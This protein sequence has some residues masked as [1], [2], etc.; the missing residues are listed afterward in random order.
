LVID[1]KLGQ[2]ELTWSSLGLRHA[3]NERG[4]AVLNAGS[5]TRGDPDAMAIDLETV[6]L[7]GRKALGAFPKL[8]VEMAGRGCFRRRPE[9][10]SSCSQ[11]RR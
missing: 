2:H 4:K 8:Q 9:L 6:T 11:R 1:L 5:V 10:V 3:L 7:F